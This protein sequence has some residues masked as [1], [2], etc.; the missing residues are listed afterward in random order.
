[1]FIVKNVFPSKKLCNMRESQLGRAWLSWASASSI[2]AWDT[3]SQLGA[4]RFGLAA[5]EQRISGPRPGGVV[6]QMQRA[7]IYIYIYTCVY[8]SPQSSEV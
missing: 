5:T 4:V 2:S 1:M 7:H 8:I 3:L 6:E